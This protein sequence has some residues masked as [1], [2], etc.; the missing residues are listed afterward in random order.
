[1]RL[2]GARPL[3]FWEECHDHFGVLQVLPCR[4][5]EAPHGRAGKEVS[6]FGT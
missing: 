3:H 4:R 6:E 5:V 2:P 1:M